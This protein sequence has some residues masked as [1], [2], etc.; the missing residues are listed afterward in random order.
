MSVI[1][2]TTTNY[3]MRSTYLLFPGFIATVFALMSHTSEEM[4]IANLP[5]LLSIAGFTYVYLICGKDI[6]I[7][8]LIQLPNIS[9]YTIYFNLATAV[10]AVSVALNLLDISGLSHLHSAGVSIAL[11]GCA[12]IEM[13]LG[14]RYQN[15][16]LRFISLGIFGIVIVKLLVFDLWRMAAI[17]R[18]IVFILLGVILLAVSF[19][20]QRLRNVLIDKL[21]Q[22]DK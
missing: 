3:R 15:K 16:L 10:Y 19:F 9:Y 5:L 7:R 21:P 4:P 11:T 14:M 13:A 8:K 6:F 12:A 17:G 22:E 2:L 18:I 20:Y 1:L